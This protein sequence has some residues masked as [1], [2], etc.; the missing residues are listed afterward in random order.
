[1][2]IFEEGKKQTHLLKPIRGCLRE[3][4]RCHSPLPVGAAGLVLQPWGTGGVVREGRPPS[5]VRPLLSH[6]QSQNPF[7]SLLGGS[8]AL[9][10]QG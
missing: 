3:L 9:N 1:M 4:K 2:Y 10:D 5:N 6:S 8:T 7:K